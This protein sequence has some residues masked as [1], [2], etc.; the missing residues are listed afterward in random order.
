MAKNHN[1][2]V[3][4]VVKRYY[5]KA[6]AGNGFLNLKS[7]LT[8]NELENYDEITAEEFDELTRVEPHVPTEEENA[9]KEK[10]ARINFLKGEL[11]RTDYVVIKIAEADNKADQDA[12]R[13]EYAEV[14]ANRIAWR[15]EINELL[16]EVEQEVLFMSSIPSYP[17]QIVPPYGKEDIKSIVQEGITNGEIVLPE[18]EPGT[19][20][21]KHSI[22]ILINNDDF[23]AYPATYTCISKRNSPI[24]ID[25]WDTFLETL[26][27][28]QEDGF[29]RISK[30]YPTAPNVSFAHT[31]VVDS[32]CQLI[33][34]S[35][36]LTEILS[37]SDTVTEL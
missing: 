26:V 4:R 15:E 5:Y 21:Y 25:P 17:K 2:V 11:A 31:K 6:K 12:I 18:V 24:T 28:P 19:K 3:T 30:A 13:E 14:I 10:L 35:V 16:A 32:V 23:P 1:E 33:T 29:E 34:N 8:A 27:V 37:F 20:L 7:P 36:A 9:R 22:Q